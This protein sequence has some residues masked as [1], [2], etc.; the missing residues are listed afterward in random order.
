MDTLELLLHRRSNKKLTH[1]APNAEQ[2]AQIFQ[3]AFRAP[4]HG[5]LQPYRFIVIEGEGLKRLEV[6]LKAA[7]QE[8]NLDE[9][10]AAKAE[11]IC[12]QPMV[13]AVVA[14]IDKTIEKVPAWEQML[15]AGCATY[16]IQLAAQNLGF[17]NVWVTGKWVD[18][19]A[20]RQA[21]ECGANDKVVALVMLGTAKG[22]PDKEP[23]PVNP[24]KFVRYL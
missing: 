2:L 7:A 16:S 22:Q 11:K 21:F 5:K 19:S 1:P 18:G 9:K 4:D 20:L 13:I 14:K 10:Q 12:G 17:D 23:K 8:L 3:A 24:D 6:L 15:T